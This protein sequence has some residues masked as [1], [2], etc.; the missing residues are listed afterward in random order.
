MSGEIRGFK[1]LDRPEYPLEALREAVVNALVHR[2]YSKVGETVRVFVYSDRVEVHSP[3]LLLPGITPLDLA[4]MRVASHPRNPVL[5]GLLRDLP[6]Y[7]ERVGS[8]I[9][10]MVTATR[11]LDLP[12]PEFLEQHEVVVI[13]RNGI[14][15]QMEVPTPLNPRQLIGLRLIHERGSISSPEYAE[16]TGAAAR[17]ALYDLREMV[18]KGILTSRGKKRGVRYYLP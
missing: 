16:A 13:F 5:A 1:R 10:L 18:D 11:Q 8:G 14:A 6:G 15:P 4:Q 7:M 9:R 12:P 2:D 3:G 17:T